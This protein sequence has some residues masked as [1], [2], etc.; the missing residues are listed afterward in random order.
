MF[1]RAWAASTILSPD[2]KMR[3]IDQAWQ[4]REQ[5]RKKINFEVNKPK[6]LDTV[7]PALASTSRE[8]MQNI[9]LKALDL[10]LSVVLKPI[11]QLTKTNLI[12]GPGVED[13]KISFEAQEMPIGNFLSALLYS[14]GYG[15]KFEEKQL[16]ILAEQTQIFRIILP[17]VTQDFDDVT[18]N[19]SFVRSSDSGAHSSQNQQVKLGTKIVVG[20]QSSGMS[21]WDDV[22][23]NV[24]ALSSPT[25]RLSLNKPAGMV[26][27][28]DTPIKL[29]GL[30]RY[31]ED[32]NAR[33]ST[34]IEVDVKVVEVRL[35]DENRFGVDWNVLAGDL[36]IL[37]SFGWAS[38]FAASNFN[39]GNYFKFNADGS[40]EGSGV[41]ANG[42]KVA[43]DALSKQGKVEVVS[44]PRV[45]ILNN[46]IAVI[47]VGSTQSY[48]DSSTIETTQTGT[49]TSVST[50]QV[51]E[52]VTMRLLANIVGDDIYLSVTPV[53]TS[54]DN[55]RSIASGNTIIEAPQTTTK[56]IN[57]LV[58]LTQGETVAIG[59][60]ITA[61]KEHSKQNVPVISKV[62]L[63]GKLF[64]YSVNKDNKT[65]LIIF[66]T[67]RKG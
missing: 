4:G 44:Q 17:P 19:E 30:R 45:R 11:A 51:Q 65:E 53:V 39:S 37:N 6:P 26:V 12:L 61:T 9:S 10:P 62:P 18:S 52:G 23:S 41:S 57:T 55:I 15:Y 25:A 1:P 48:I 34:Q 21:F 64:Q 58:K 42:F 47:Q 7:S 8:L 49:V 36:K 54:I 22:L 60:L 43:I 24:K 40:K 31:F 56:S 27:V 20:S 2:Q 35:N 38:N 28:T 67:P 13:K 32:L 33:V 46:Q 63:L 29:D 59:G 50:S 3:I 14:V 66:I 5:L 16:I